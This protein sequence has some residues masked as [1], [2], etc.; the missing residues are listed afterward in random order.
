MVTWL[1]ETLK[2][3]IQK[4]FKPRYGRELTNEE[5][6]TIATNLVSFMESVAGINKPNL[7]S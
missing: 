3:E 6:E 1:N 5:L 4:V 2:A 7:N